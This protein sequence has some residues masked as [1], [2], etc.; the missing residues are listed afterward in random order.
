MAGEKILRERFGSFEL[1]GG[2]SRAKAG[3][4]E[5][6]EAVNDTGDERRLGADDCQCD[7]LVL[8]ELCEGVY[9]IRLYGNVADLVLACRTG[10]SRGDEHLVDTW[11]LSAFPREGMFAATRANNQN[12]HQCRKCR[13]PVKTIA[14][15]CSLAAWMTSSSR[16]EPPG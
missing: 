15:P 11:R 1:G 6:V 2:R 13:M 8:C 10:V 7:I 3:Q 9:V 4:A 5:R 16:I 14:R 12:V